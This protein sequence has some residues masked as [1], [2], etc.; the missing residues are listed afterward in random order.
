MGGKF[1]IYD[2]VIILIP[3]FVL[4]LR[5]PIVNII[6][7]KRPILEHGVVSFIVEGFVEIIES[8]SY[9]ISNSISFVRVAAFA[10]SHTVLSLIVFKLSELLTISSGSIPGIFILIIGNI[11]IILL[12]GLIVTIQVIRLEYY[13]FFS[14]F[15]T[16]IGK[17][18]KPFI[19]D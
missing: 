10:L 5:K 4:F 3:L 17:E 16:E 15:F 1:T 11:I 19:L 12:E 6:S 8:V 9:Y 2:L 14:K 7:K 18:F 13:E